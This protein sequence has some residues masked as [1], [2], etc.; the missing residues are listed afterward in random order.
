[1]SSLKKGNIRERWESKLAE[2]LYDRRKAVP[3]GLCAQGREEVIISL[4]LSLCLSPSLPLPLSREVV[5]PNVSL[6]S[7]KSGVEAEL[8]DRTNK[9]IYTQKT[10]VVYLNPSI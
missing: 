1:M 10:I 8:P 6:S 5:N 2:K 3:A 4:H 9:N 7:H